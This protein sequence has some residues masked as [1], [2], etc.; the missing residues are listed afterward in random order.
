MKQLFNVLALAFLVI[1]LASCSKDD[2]TP[3]G[4]DGLVGNWKLVEY[5]YTGSGTTT[6]GGFTTSTDFSG[7]GKNMSAFVEFTENPNEY[8]SMG[9]IDIELTVNS[10][11]QTYTITQTT[12]GDFDDGTWEKNDNTLSLVNKNGGMIDGTITELTG[13]TLKLTYQ[14]TVT[15][16]QNGATTVS[17]INAVQ[18]YEKQ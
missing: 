3:S 2:V 8:V 11:G 5:T 9:M 17:N 6:V 18:S 7:V 4:G 1:G 14:T 16:T 13:N 10:G 12:S 15:D